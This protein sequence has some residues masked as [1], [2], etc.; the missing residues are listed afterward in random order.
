[1]SCACS[2]SACCLQLTTRHDWAQYLRKQRF[3]DC[4]LS[5]TSP[6]QLPAIHS[7]ILGGRR[8]MVWQLAQLPH[9]LRQLEALPHRLRA[10]K[11]DGHLRTE[12][13][14]EI[15]HVSLAAPT[16]RADWT[17]ACTQPG[18]QIASGKLPGW[19]TAG[20]RAMSHPVVSLD[21]VAGGRGE[22]TLMQGR[23]LRTWWGHPAGMN[24]ASPGYCSKCHGSTP[25]S[26]FSAA[27]CLAVSMN[28]CIPTYLVSSTPRRKS[29]V[30]SMPR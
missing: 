9:L 5:D 4:R 30:L 13:R 2:L 22:Q 7:P 28:V 8:G 27:R 25:Y 19:N 16:P 29:L 21:G 17:T 20:G 6:P 10:H 11:V 1:M 12:A 23:R 15:V 18:L 3:V 24:T 14:H 26:A